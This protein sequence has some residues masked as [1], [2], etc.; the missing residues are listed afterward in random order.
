MKKGYV[1]A[2]AAVALLSFA[3]C[4]TSSGSGS[5]IVGVRDD[6]IGFSYLNEE[7]GKYYGLEID[8]AE[9]L[10][11]RLG[12]AQ[13]E[14]VTVTPESRKDILLNG[15]VDCLIATYSIT[16]SRLENFDFSPAYYHDH[17]VVMVEKSTGIKKIEDLVGTTVGTLDGANTAPII[18]DKMI[19]S[20]LITAEDTKGTSLTK[21]SSYSELSDALEDGSV[22]AVC[23]DGGI[24]NAYMQEDREILE[25]ML[26]DED[27]G[28]A[29][30][31][32]SDLSERVEDAVS[33]M[34]DDGTIDKLIDKWD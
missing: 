3:G 32:D 14:Y 20:G 26:S 22:D 25:E 31:K 19:G 34:L 13:V 9:E 16:D 5:L 1:L 10:A 28:I 2:M 29:T 30:N 18:S 6:I 8:L 23:L 21:L 7:T 12:Y 24:A 33:G 11:D 15:E 17:A 4:E 27:Y